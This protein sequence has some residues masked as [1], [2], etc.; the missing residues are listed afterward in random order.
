MHR[1]F[2]S[3]EGNASFSVEKSE[4]TC[5]DKNDRVNEKQLAD[6]LEGAY[7]AFEHF[8]QDSN[9]CISGDELSPCRGLVVSCSFHATGMTQ[10][11]KR[12]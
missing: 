12:N 5:K 4:E 1:S 11:K 8:D 9:G 10:K 3:Q 7:A 6:L 2:S